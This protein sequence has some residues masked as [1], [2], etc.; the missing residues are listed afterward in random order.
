[1]VHI[2]KIVTPTITCKMDFNKMPFDRHTCYFV[3]FTEPGA[4]IVTDLKDADFGYALKARQHT[5]FDY[6]IEFK[7]LPKLEINYVKMYDEMPEVVI[8]QLKQ[9]GMEIMPCTGFTMVLTREWKRFIFVYYLPSSMFVLT[10]W[11]SFLIPPKVQI[12]LIEIIS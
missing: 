11:A 1:M 3:L 8:S 10:S 5:K 7:S 4:S 12:F 9:F 6:G 2:I